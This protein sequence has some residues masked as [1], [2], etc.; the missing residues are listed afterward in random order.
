M[1]DTDENLEID[2][3]EWLEFSANFLTI[4]RDTFDSIMAT[5]LDQ[6]RESLLPEGERFRDKNAPVTLPKPL[7]TRRKSESDPAAKDESPSKAFARQRGLSVNVA[8]DEDETPVVC[9]AAP[10]VPRSPAGWF[11]G[12]CSDKSCSNPAKIACA[13][14]KFSLCSDHGTAHL[15]EHMKNAAAGLETGDSP[16]KTAQQHLNVISRVDS[17][18]GFFPDALQDNVIDSVAAQE[19]D[20]AGTGTEEILKSQS[21][22]AIAEDLE[23][24]CDA[25]HA[26]D[27]TE[28]IAA[29]PGSSHTQADVVIKPSSGCTCVI[30]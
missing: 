9:K 12:T 14:C 18:F 15:L 10:S 28:D 11:W 29:A 26:F 22:A 5:Y 27:E 6:V 8:P 21:P 20:G 3:G 1:A 19:R 30:M 23:T 24:E 7:C 25:V 13:K 16:D 17:R 4:P 2:L